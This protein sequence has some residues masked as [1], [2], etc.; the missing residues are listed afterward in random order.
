V[1]ITTKTLFYTEL[2]SALKVLPVDI[3]INQIR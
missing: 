3:E 1:C 2:R